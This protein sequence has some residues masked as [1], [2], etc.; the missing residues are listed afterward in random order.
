MNKEDS[1]EFVQERLRQNHSLLGRE[2]RL[3]EPPRVRRRFAVEMQKGEHRTFERVD[4]SVLVCCS[5]GSLW[6][7]HDGDPK[8]V[9]LVAGEHH[10]ADREDAMHLFAMQP[11]VIEI[12]FDDEVVEH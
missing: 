6:I 12:Q 7:T 9:I 5:S 2:L 3:K 1:L 11:S 10:W 8:D 4:A